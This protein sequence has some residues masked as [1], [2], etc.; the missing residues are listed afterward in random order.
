MTWKND[1]VYSRVDKVI[2]YVC[3]LL[4]QLAT[5]NT[6]SINNQILYFTL[7][8]RNWSK[9][10]SWTLAMK[11]MEYRPLLLP[12]CSRVTGGARWTFKTMPGH[13][14]PAWDSWQQ[15][16]SVCEL[17]SSSFCGHP[18]SPVPTLPSLVL[19]S[20]WL[21]ILFYEEESLFEEKRN[22]HNHC[23]NVIFVKICWVLKW[24]AQS[25]VWTCKSGSDL[26]SFL[27]CLWTSVLN[28][29]FFSF[30]FSPLESTLISPLPAWVKD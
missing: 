18:A 6:D 3:L 9:N 26:H 13:L 25:D 8:W 1:F 17:Q 2:M 10:Y 12:I 22:Y 16:L 5:T 21:C 20:L 19:S 29:F 11:Y 14:C 30:C 28:I 24:T 4:T 7:T 27:V 15:A 23:H